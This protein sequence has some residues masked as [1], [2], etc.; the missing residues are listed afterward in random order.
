MKASFILAL[1]AI[2]AAAATPQVKERQVPTLLDT[3]CLLQVA[4]ISTCFP[5][6]DINS[7][8]EIDEIFVCPF[9][10][11]IR[12]LT[13]CPAIPAIPKR[14]NVTNSNMADIIVFLTPKNLQKF[15]Q[16]AESGIVYK[17]LAIMGVHDEDDERQLSEPPV[18]R[19]ELISLLTK[20][21][22]ALTK[23]SGNPLGIIALR[24]HAKERPKHQTQI[25]SELEERST[26]KSTWQC[27][28]DT[29]FVVFAAMH[30]GG[31]V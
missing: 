17:N 22:T 2:A 14:L 11:I 27:T 6:L 8:V 7:V 16:D 31:L 19:E 5:N 18:T 13:Q 1:P 15:V 28:N 23:D 29:F 21:F 30:H 24:I 12:I 26:M 4:D 25:K 10:I 20:A 3:A 9:K